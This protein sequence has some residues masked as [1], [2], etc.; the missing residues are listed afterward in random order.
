VQAL[1]ELY[2]DSTHE[3]FL[4]ALDTV[5]GGSTEAVDKRVV[6]LTYGQAA[7]LIEQLGGNA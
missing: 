3:G 7:Q 6:A 2:R 5:D 1:G 4:A